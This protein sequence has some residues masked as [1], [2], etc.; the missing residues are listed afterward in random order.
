MD[1]TAYY[2]IAF[3]HHTIMN[4]LSDDVLHQIGWHCFPDSGRVL[5]IGSGKG[6][7]SLFFAREHEAYCVQ[8]DS[9]PIWTEAAR[10]L[11]AGEELLGSTEIHCMDAADFQAGTG[12]YHCILCLGTA[13]VYGGFSD[14]L[15]RLVPALTP[16]GVLV[17]GEISTDRPLPGPYR[18]YLS[19]QDWEI[20]STEEIQRDLAANGL[21][22]LFAFRSD[23][24]EWDLYMGLQWKAIS[25]YAR[26]HPADEQAAEFLAWARKEQEMYLRYQRHY[27]DW[28]VYVLRQAR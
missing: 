16:D 14:A 17:L 27:A 18:R 20:P 28:T 25:D 21:E 1:F 3:R 19:R 15:A 11:F 8:V 22:T 5:D 4:P 9:S 7:V 24:R 2:H 10:Q 12:E 23:S 13:P 26:Q 6:Y